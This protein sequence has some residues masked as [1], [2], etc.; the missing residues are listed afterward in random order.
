M[1]PSTALRISTRRA[2]SVPKCARI[3]PRTI[4]ELQITAFR[5][6]AVKSARS[7]ARR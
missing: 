3:S 6:A 7:A 4:S 2:A 1:A 5:R